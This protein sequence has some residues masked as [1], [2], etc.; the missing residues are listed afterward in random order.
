[1]KLTK[2]MMRGLLVGGVAI[3]AACATAKPSVELTEARR[4][5]DEAEKSHAPELAPDKMLDARQYMVK[6]EKAHDEDPGSEREKQLA[7]LANRRAKVA[8]AHGELLDAQ[9]DQAQ[10]KDMYVRTQSQIIDR[11]KQN[12][13]QLRDAHAAATQALMSTEAELAEVDRELENKDDL[14]KSR[15][16][17]LEERADALRA[18]KEDLTAKRDDLQASLEQ[19]DQALESEREAREKAEQR[20]NDALKSLEEIAKVK[21]ELEETV[22]TL[23]G[24]V[25][26]EFGTAKLLPIAKTKLSEVAAALMAQGE[27]KRIVVEGHTDSKGSTAFND[28]LSQRRAEVVRTFLIDQGVDSNRIVAVGR[29]ESEPVASN[30]TPEGR[31]NNRRVE[32]VLRD[33]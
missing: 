6:A 14:M 24:S 28:D 20:A 18:E 19:K 17:E 11:T 27:N 26:F 9:R 31:A 4:V 32:I 16:S 1:M 30:T 7:Y 3:T 25:V 5:Y 8:M 2:N 22:I 12:N 23:S 10:A 15:V 13:R 21:A 29:G 33:S